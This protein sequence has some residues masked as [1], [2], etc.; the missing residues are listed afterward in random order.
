MS[1]HHLLILLAVAG[2]A[3]LYCRNSAATIAPATLPT[4]LWTGSAK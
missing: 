4:D 1:K 2:A 3:Y